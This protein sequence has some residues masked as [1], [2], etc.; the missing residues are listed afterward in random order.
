MKLIYRIGKK[1]FRVYILQKIKNFS[2]KKSASFFFFFHK[3]SFI[4][5]NENYIE[6]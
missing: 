2:D 3:I 1:S 6:H 5:E 4:E